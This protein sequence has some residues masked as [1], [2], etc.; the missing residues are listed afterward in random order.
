MTQGGAADPTAGRL[1][2]QPPTC[3]L[4]CIICRAAASLRTVPEL[5]KVSCSAT[6][7]DDVREFYG[8]QFWKGELLYV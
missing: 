7:A 8:S 3:V 4:F 2:S 5:P 1:L 6:G